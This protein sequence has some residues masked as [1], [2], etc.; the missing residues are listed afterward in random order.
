[1]ATSAARLVRQ[2]KKVKAAA[3][4]VQTQALAWPSLAFL[5]RRLVEVQSGL[6]GKLPGQFVV[7]GRHGLGGAVLQGHP[8]AGTGGLVEN[9][10]QKLGDAAF[11][12]AEAGHEQTAESDQPRP[13]LAGGDAV[14]QVAAG[15]AAAGTDEAV[16]LVFGDQWLDLGQ[17]PNLMTQGFGVGAGQGF[18]AASAGRRQ[19]GH[20]GLALLDGDQGPFV[21]GMPRLAAGRAALGAFGSQRLG[22]R[23]RGRRRQGGIAGV[24][25]ELGFQF[26]HA[27][28]QDANLRC[29]QLKDRNRRR[30]QRG[31]DLRR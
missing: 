29:L 31:P 12:L 27:G 2:A 6:V 16:S 7:G 9:H 13:G 5:G 26:G 28:G 11:G 19:A 10:A 8:P 1:M 30:R 25:A 20:D 3:T 18:A 15:G 4:K 14:G 21:L 17:F 23:V 24:F 22:V